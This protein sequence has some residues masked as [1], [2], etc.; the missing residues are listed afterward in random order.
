MDGGKGSDV[1]LIANASEHSAAEITDSG[2]SGVDVLRF[3]ATKASTLTLYA[4]DTGLEQVIFDTGTV[5]LSVNGAA[6]KNGLLL[7]GNAGL[8]TLTGT[9][10]ADTLDGGAGSD[11]LV[12]GSGNDT[13]IVDITSTGT[14]QD[15][16]TES[17]NDNADAL[18]LRG[19]SSNSTAAAINL[20]TGLEILDAS[21]TGNSLLN[22][23]GNTANNTLTGNAANNVISGGAGNDWLFGGLGA[24]T[25]DGGTGNDVFAYSATVQSDRALTDVVK[26]V[27]FGGVGPGNA[28]DRFHFDGLTLTQATLLNN[29]STNAMNTL[30]ALQNTLSFMTA[31]EAV[32]LNVTS[33]VGAGTY[34][35]VDANGTQGYQASG[36]YAIQLLGVSNLNNFDLSD[37]LA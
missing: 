23:N 30:A 9:A 34:L 14:L 28:V 20:T 35:F 32:L 22:L 18:V 36:D 24:D 7:T 21:A 19:T 26:N 16:I 13:Y 5:A 29:V 3:T 31:G 4:G 6:V 17:G 10:F 2:S 8:N 11:K 1:Y 27:D 15:T 25:L 37:L 12:G 33:G